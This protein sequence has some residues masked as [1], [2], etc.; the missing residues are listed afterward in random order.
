MLFPLLSSSLY[1][2]GS[3]VPSLHMRKLRFPEAKIS[4]PV[5]G[6]A[7]CHTQ[8]FWLKVHCLF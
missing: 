1:Q 7:V 3:S 8:V 4:Q 2:V 6:R 5:N